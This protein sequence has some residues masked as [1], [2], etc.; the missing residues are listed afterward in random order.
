MVRNPSQLCRKRTSCRTLNIETTG[1]PC[2]LKG[3][4]AGSWFDLQ[5]AWAHASLTV[6]GAT[7]KHSFAS[8]VVPAGTLLLAVSLDTAAL[9]WCKV[10]G[11]RWVFPHHAVRASL[12]V[13]TWTAMACLPVRCFPPLACILDI[14][15]GWDSEFQGC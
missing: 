1:I 6:S 5:E 10:L 7:C 14:F 9:G 12:C 2:L 3:I 4:S 13:Q 8:T 15:S 11:D